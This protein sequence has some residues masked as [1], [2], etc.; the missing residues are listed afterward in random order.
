MKVLW[1]SNWLVN[2][3]SVGGATNKY[4]AVKLQEYETDATLDRFAQMLF[5]KIKWHLFL[6]ASWQMRMN[7]EKKI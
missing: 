4:Y 6:P 3:S 2:V 1:Q 7:N 5:G